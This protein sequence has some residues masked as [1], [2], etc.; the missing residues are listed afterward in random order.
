MTRNLHFNWSSWN[1]KAC[2]FR[3]RQ[4]R[5]KILT[6]P[7]PSE[8]GW[9]SGPPS[10]LSCSSSAVWFKSSS[11]KVS[12]TTNTLSTKSLNRQSLLEISRKFTNYFCSRFVLYEEVVENKTHLDNHFF[13]FEGTQK[14]MLQ[15]NQYIR[16]YFYILQTLTKW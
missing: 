8:V 6:M 7:R 14:I 3:F 1:F 5:E 15:H 16:S 9:H 2:S 4:W 12:S 13:L 10:T 11:S